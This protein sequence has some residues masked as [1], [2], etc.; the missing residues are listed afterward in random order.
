VSD[1]R[2]PFVLRVQDDDPGR[3][4][5][6]ARAL[7]G[8]LADREALARVLTSARGRPGCSV[9]IGVADEHAGPRW[10]APLEVPVEPGLAAREVMTFLERWGFVH[11][12]APSAPRA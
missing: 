8:P 10:L 12:P 5:A 11:A 7:E 6:L 9:A 1:V 2:R 4:H 3:A